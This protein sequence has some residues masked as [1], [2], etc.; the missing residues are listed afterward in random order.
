MSSTYT[1]SLTLTQI[2]NG[3][4]SGTWGTTTNTNW[5]LIEDSVAG[6]AQVTVSGSTGA[7]LSVANGTTDQSRNAVIVVT[8]SISTSVAI[9]APLVKKVYIISNQTSG[10]FA[11]TIGATTGSTVSIANGLTTLVYCDGT[12]FFS[13]ITGFTGGNLSITGTINATGTITAPVINAS[14]YGGATNKIP[15]QTGSSATSFIDAPPSSGSATIL[16]YTPGS[17]FSWSTGTVSALAGGTTNSLVYQSSPGVTQFFAK[18]GT[19][20]VYYLTYNGGSNS[21]V[22]SLGG[23]VASVT[24]SSPLGITGT[25]TNPNV[26]ITGLVP[27]ANGGTGATTLAGANIAVLSN[28]GTQTFAGTINAQAFAAQG[29]GSTS[30]QKFSVS[31][32]S[33]GTT[34]SSG[35]SPT[36]I[37]LGA[38]GVGAFYDPTTNNSFRIITTFGANATF[39]NDGLN[40]QGNLNTAWYNPSD[41]NIKTNVRPISA[42]LD[43]I[44]ALKPCHF[45]YKHKVGETRTGFIAQEFETVF[46]GHVEEGEADENFRKFLPEGQ[47]KIKGITQ[48]LIPYLVQAI[49]ELS[50]EVTAL[51]AKVGA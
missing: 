32:T 34:Y 33:G 23:S 13:G 8:G 19:S 12:N 17:G 40:Y 18:P 38:S 2:G 3:E 37:Q 16:T 48:D 36:T 44:N 28:T 47:T 42:V 26:S 14:L 49:Q 31:Y 45:E 21:F 6:V 46:P 4:Q 39:R 1:T 24:A 20:D 7:T 41:I 43:K 5:Q 10:G 30:D 25:S 35:L 9:V 50:A 51:K 29:A 15:V 22:W 11:I 27:I